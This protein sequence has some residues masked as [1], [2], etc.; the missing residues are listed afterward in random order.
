MDSVDSLELMR[1]K[2]EKEKA[3]EM[4]LSASE[5]GEKRPTQPSKAIEPEVVKTL[6]PVKVELRE[7]DKDLPFKV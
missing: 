6:V 2:R 4:E 3:R 7:E 1:I 5:G